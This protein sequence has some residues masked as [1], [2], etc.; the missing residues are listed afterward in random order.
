MR[1]CV[2]GQLDGKRPVRWG[3]A[4]LATCLLGTVGALGAVA[5]SFALGQWLKADLAR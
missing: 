5:I 4:I 3:A 2:V 1:I